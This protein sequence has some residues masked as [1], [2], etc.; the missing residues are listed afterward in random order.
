MYN[1]LGYKVYQSFTFPQVIY[2]AVNLSNNHAMIHKELKIPSSE[3]FIKDLIE[4]FDHIEDLSVDFQNNKPIISNIIVQVLKKLHVFWNVH[5][6]NNNLKNLHSTTLDFVREILSKFLRTNQAMKAT[7][8][9]ILYHIKNAYY[10]FMRAQK[11]ITLIR[12]KSAEILTVEILRRYKNNIEAIHS[13]ESDAKLRVSEVARILDLLRAFFLIN[14]YKDTTDQKNLGL[15][16][17]FIFDKIKEIFEQYQ[18]Y[19]LETG[20]QNYN[21]FKDFTA[22]LLLKMELRKHI[23]FY[24]YTIQGYSS[25]PTTSFQKNFT[26][27]AKIFYEFNDSLLVIPNLC[28]GQRGFQLEGCIKRNLTQLIVD[29]RT[30]YQFKTSISGSE[31]DTYLQRATDT[32]FEECQ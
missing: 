21:D 19:L 14:Y 6:Q 32:I 27:A 11:L 9:D 16:Q 29:F 8:I 4:K 28:N 1:P 5:R 30:K 25:M 3:E 26:D 18:K 22:T 17:T 23:I 7:T 2:E 13:G 15:Y 31:M 20:D 10:R 24:Q 12:E